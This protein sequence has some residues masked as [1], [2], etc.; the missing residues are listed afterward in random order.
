MADLAPR[1]GGRL[2]GVVAKLYWGYYL[3]ARL[4]GYEVTRSDK[5]QGRFA[6]TGRL[7]PG[8][9]DAFK[10]RQKPLRF[11]A[12]FRNSAGR[13]RALEWMVVD[14]DIKDGVVTAQ[15]TPI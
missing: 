13:E 4:E 15:L 1:K 14:S 5:G 2:R 12:P 10:L 6:L 9:A 8:T 7:V 3:A 11:V